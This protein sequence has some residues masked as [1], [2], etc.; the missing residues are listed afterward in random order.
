MQ[1]L[2]AITT[3]TVQ[4]TLAELEKGVLT[5]EKFDYL[6]DLSS[7]VPDTTGGNT[8]KLQQEFPKPEEGDITELIHAIRVGENNMHETNTA[9]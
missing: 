7:V 8:C 1:N 4:E 3:D 6:Q 2:E 9:L 5:L